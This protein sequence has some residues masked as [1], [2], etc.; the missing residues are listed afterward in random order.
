MKKVES[1]ALVYV[2]PQAEFLRVSVEQDFLG[3]LTSTGSGQDVTMLDEA[4]FDEFFN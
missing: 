3:S 4:D 2:A 1:S